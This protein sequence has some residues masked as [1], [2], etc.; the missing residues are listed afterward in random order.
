M[1]LVASRLPLVVSIAT[2]ILIQCLLT[3]MP[4][5]HHMTGP[6]W[7]WLIVVSGFWSAVLGIWGS[8]RVLLFAVLLLGVSLPPPKCG[9]VLPL[10]LGIGRLQGAVVIVGEL[11]G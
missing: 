8:S 3:M 11:L 2:P 5:F 6:P 4:F 10:V 1:I 7:L 9:L